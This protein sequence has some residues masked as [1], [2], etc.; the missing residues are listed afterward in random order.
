VRLVAK[1]EP[2]QTR[3]ETVEPNPPP[4]AENDQPEV[5]G[6]ESLGVVERF[7]ALRGK[8]IFFFVAKKCVDPEELA[9]ETLERVYKKLCDS[10]K[11]SNLTAYS[12]GVA[13]NVLHEYLR[14]NRKMLAFMDHQKYQPE[15]VSSEESDAVIRERKLACW[16]EC[17]DQ[18]KEPERAMLLEYYQVEGRPKLEHR[19]R[20][21]ERLNITR[22]ALTLRVFRLK[23]EL[24]K[25]AS[26]R[27]EIYE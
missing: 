10:T 20:M 2:R 22:D 24:K 9:D 7:T 16:Q 21:A 5:P 14:G 27:L 26:A 19:Q 18:L 6:G 4:N 1:S 12:F 15:A 8:L 23:E 3:E 17:L 25:R 13:R 11:V